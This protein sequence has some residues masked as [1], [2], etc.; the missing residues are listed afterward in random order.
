[1]TTRQARLRADLLWCVGLTL[2]F[3]VV[4]IFFRFG[5]GLQATR[6]TR[7]LGTYTFGLRIHHGYMGVLLVFAAP[8]LRR[9]PFLQ[10]WVLRVGFALIFSDLVH[11]FLVLWPIT[12]S[13]QFD[14]TYQ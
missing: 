4:S 1:M 3:E 8:G 5:L 10:R 14:V 9:W 6:D 11:H 12:G 2:L 13:P 7:P